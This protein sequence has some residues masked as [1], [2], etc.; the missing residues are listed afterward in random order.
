LTADD[1]GERGSS[2]VEHPGTSASLLISTPG[3]FSPSHCL[4]LRL[5]MVSRGT[6]R[7]GRYVRRG[8]REIQRIGAVSCRDREKCAKVRGLIRGP[9]NGDESRVARVRCVRRGTR[10]GGESDRG[11]A[12]DECGNARG[13]M[14]RLSEIAPTI[15]FPARHSI[16]NVTPHTRL[17]CN[18]TPSERRHFRLRHTIVSR[19]KPETI[20]VGES[21]KSARM[22][23]PLL[24]N[25]AS[26]FAVQS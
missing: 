22:L 5:S 15:R 26:P 7:G 6:R 1:E 2:G 25:L 3:S 13:A 23:I 12:H 18:S 14:P 4:S 21:G 17:V 10:K 11:D 20:I 19:Q 8:R 9:S 24:T 16:G